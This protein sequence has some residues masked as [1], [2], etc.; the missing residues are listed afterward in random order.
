M[1][2][3]RNCLELELM[4]SV[5]IQEQIELIN[6]VAF[7]RDGM[8]HR[9]ANR[10]SIATPTSSDPDLKT[11]NEAYQALVNRFME[12][13]EKDE[14]ARVLKNNMV[15]TN[16]DDDVDIVLQSN[17]IFKNMYI[18][19]LHIFR[20]EKGMRNQHIKASCKVKITRM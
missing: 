1:E 10:T 3:L 15:T 11:V 2:S 5:S 7:V 6:W 20:Y 4:N 18:N 16:D 14:V 12:Q 8:L 17:T 13:N 9:A 19:E